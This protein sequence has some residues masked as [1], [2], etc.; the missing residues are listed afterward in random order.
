MMG[1]DF[2]PYVLN[3]NGNATNVV[4][5]PV[6]WELDDA[7]HF[8]FNFVPYLVGLSAPS[9][10]YEIWTAEFEGAYMNNGVF[11]LTMHPQIIGR[12]HRL[13]MLEKLIAHISQHPDV[14]F[15]TCSDVAGEWLERSR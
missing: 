12:Y 14:S 10:V 15:A 3:H 11:T 1:D 2:I 9:K 4:E 6:S 7:P 8:L 13:K 5:L